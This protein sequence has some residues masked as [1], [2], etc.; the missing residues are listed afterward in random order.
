MRGKK[1]KIIRKILTSQGIDIKSEN[2]RKLYQEVKKK[3]V[4]N[5]IQTQMVS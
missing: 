1:A 3:N 2:N 4:Y 5:K